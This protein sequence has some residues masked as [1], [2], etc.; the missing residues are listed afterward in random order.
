MPGNPPELR[1]FT[2]PEASE[3][4]GRLTAAFLRKC[5]A[6]FGYSGCLIL[7]PV[8]I[9][10]V[11]FFMV[12]TPLVSERLYC[13]H[14]LDAMC[15]NVSK[16]I[17]YTSNKCPDYFPHGAWE[18]IPGI[19]FP[20]H[21]LNT[22]ETGWY[23]KVLNTTEKNALQLD[24]DNLHG[25]RLPTISAT[26]EAW[27]HISVFI[28]GTGVC[29]ICIATIFVTML[30]M[31]KESSLGHY[32][33]IPKDALVPSGAYISMV[34]MWGVVGTSMRGINADVI[35]LHNI[36]AV[37][38]FLISYATVLLFVIQR[39]PTYQVCFVCFVC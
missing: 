30:Y 9:G 1:Y 15:I 3:A 26:I 34:L 31:E 35:T 4:R 16:Y 24:F 19:R 10:M 29:N 8:T 12:S 37:S 20:D 2:L 14:A 27:P 13:P 33:L 22:N 28:L 11:V 17:A 18:A 39:P 38:M 36:V 23:E 21:E 7:G 5:V 25:K 32:F 6:Y